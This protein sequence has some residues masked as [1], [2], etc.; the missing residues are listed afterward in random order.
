MTYDE[1][2]DYDSDL[3]DHEDELS[4]GFGVVSRFRGD[5]D[6]SELDDLDS[7]AEVF[8]AR[9]DRQREDDEPVLKATTPAPVR[10]LHEEAIEGFRSP[11]PFEGVGVALCTIF[12]DQGKLDAAATADLASQLVDCGVAA[13]VVAGTTGEAV[14]LSR[15]ERRKLVKKVVGAVQGAVPVFAG[16]GAP[17]AHQA[18]RY[19]A[20]AVDLGVD[21]LLVLSPQNVDDPRRY[22]DAVGKDSGGVPVL[23]Y[24][25][26]KWSAP[27]VP[28]GVLND[29][30]VAGIKDSSGDA[31]RML[32]TI[33]EY[34]GAFYTGSES[35]LT[36]AG[37]LGAA[38]AISGLANVEPELCMRAFEADAEAQRELTSL[39]QMCGR[40]FPS[41]LKELVAARYG[42]SSVSRL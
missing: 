21:G 11:A 8:L 24:H 18:V 36:A 5:N 41:T 39:V 12:D 15:K 23:S 27:G 22:Y 38:G 28:L 37:S 35:L 31:K 29:L 10:A 32:E 33:T 3:N 2:D 20:D 4:D 9:F 19:T 17:S 40:G 25:Y 42:V 14:T 1:F 6:L 30:P 26:P 13:L 16:T 7:M 34:S